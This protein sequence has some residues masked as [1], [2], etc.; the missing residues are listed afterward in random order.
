MKIQDIT[1]GLVKIPLRT[2]FKTALRTVECVEDIVIKITAE[3]GETGYGEAPPTKAITGETLSSIANALGTY[4]IPAVKGM[5]LKEPAVI[6][7]KIQNCIPGN[8]SAKAAMDM[9]VYDLT[10]KHTEIPLCILLN[11]STNLKKPLMTDLTISV[12][13]VEQMVLDAKEAVARGFQSLKIKVGKEGIKDL[14]RIHEI[15][16]AIGDQVGIRV[17]ANQGWTPQQAVAILQQAQDMK[18]NLEFVEQPVKAADISGMAY[19]K[20]NTQIPIVA[21]ESAFH[22]EDAERIFYENAADMVNIK[23]MKAGGIYEALKIAEIAGRYGKKCM[24]GCMLES[25]IAVS[26]A[27]HFAAAMGDVVTAV[28]L[29]GPSL[30]AVDPYIGGPA[31]QD[32][33]IY[34]NETQGIGITGIEQNYYEEMEGGK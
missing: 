14:E 8:S 1:I 17:D 28:D 15:R 6:L 30:C 3:D 5:D 10:A 31:F 33:Y 11:K 19:I 34:M 7:Q 29:D 12:N 27:A 32:P 25:K 18:L 2:P 16:A 24:I 9:A 13:P 4:L 23:L 21:D 22:P 20:A 26:A